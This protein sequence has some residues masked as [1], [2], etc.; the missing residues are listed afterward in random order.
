MWASCGSILLIEHRWLDRSVSRQ[1]RCKRGFRLY[2]YSQASLRSAVRGRCCRAERP[3]QQA[4]VIAVAYLVPDAHQGVTGG[5]VGNHGNT[6]CASALPSAARSGRF[7][8]GLVRSVAGMTPP[9][10]PKRKRQ[11]DDR[12]LRVA[13]DVGVAGPNSG[14]SHVFAPAHDLTDLPSE[15]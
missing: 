2:T 4:A 10:M 13:G 14:T 12:R 7:G 8:S 9:T 15:A 6:K 11:P 5:R 1:S 3:R